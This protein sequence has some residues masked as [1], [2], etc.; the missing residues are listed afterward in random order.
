[1]RVAKLRE[2]AAERPRLD[3]GAVVPGAT[4]QRQMLIELEGMRAETNRL[5]EELA[6]KSR[7]FAER[8]HELSMQV[9]SLES[10]LNA[11]T[12]RAEV[13][14]SRSDMNIDEV[15]ATGHEEL[16]AELAATRETL[17]RLQK[18]EKERVDQVANL[19]AQFQQQYFELE[20]LRESKKNLQ[21]LLDEWR[22]RARSME[23]DQQQLKKRADEATA[24]AD[25]LERGSKGMRE[26]ISKLEGEI[27][28]RDRELEMA[29]KRAEH[30]RRHLKGA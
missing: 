28:A 17:E 5:R 14:E 12:E 6:E 1:M 18:N 23:K 4:D 19:Q 10:Q 7:M 30:L 13:A 20:Q 9:A 21:G 24:S 26:H 29:E 11:T 15:M 25:R 22:Q 16:K 27:E 3:L 2:L 8:E